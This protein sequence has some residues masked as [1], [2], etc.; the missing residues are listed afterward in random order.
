MWFFFDAA[1]DTGLQVV[2]ITG[3]AP[4]QH[5]FCEFYKLLL[6]WFSHWLLMIAKSHKAPEKAICF[7][8]CMSTSSI[9]HLQNP[10]CKYSMLYEVLFSKQNIKKC[11]RVGNTGIYIILHECIWVFITRMQMF[12]VLSVYYQTS[13][14]IWTCCHSQVYWQH[15]QWV[16]TNNEVSSVFRVPSKI[17]ALKHLRILGKQMI[18]FLSTPS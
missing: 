11:C 15:H 7:F 1:T 14:R 6:G 16:I 12:Y 10:Q 3:V 13:S 18:A 5:R 9:H 2:Q 4:V 17:C 8:C